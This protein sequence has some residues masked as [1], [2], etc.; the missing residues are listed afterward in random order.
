MGTP[1][2]GR[3][4]RSTGDNLDLRLASAVGVGSVS[5]AQPHLWDLTH[6]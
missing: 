1:T 4:D 5:R 3:L 6:R 2:Y